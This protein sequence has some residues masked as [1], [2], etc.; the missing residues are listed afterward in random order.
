MQY[1][2]LPSVS[3]FA[4]PLTGRTVLLTGGNVGLG[5]EAAKHLA[6]LGPERL[7]ITSRNAARGAEAVKA[8]QA[9]GKGKVGSVECWEIDQ[10]QFGSVTA[11]ADRWAKE[12]GKLDLLV[13]NAG[14]AQLEY[15]QSQDGLELMLQVNHLAPALLTFRMLPFLSKASPDPPTPRIVIV[16]SGTHHWV[17]GV[18]EV[19]EAGDGWLK[20]LASKKYCQTEKGMM[21]RYPLTKLFNVMFAK[22]LSEHIPASNP[23]IANSVNPGFCRSSLGRNVRSWR[24]W[25]YTQL[26][27]RTTEVGS[28]TLVHAAVGKDLDDMYGEYV[29]SCFVSSP[30]ALVRSRRGKMIRDKLWAQTIE[31]LSEV[32]PEVPRIIKQYLE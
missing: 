6:S 28:R 29:E 20:L 7:I 18:Q 23:L 19:D 2:P 16:N 5:F 24:F 21:M 11:F 25:F 10:A 13:L 17:P 9:A 27:A 4:R 15:A 1:C 8:I 32:D 26:V 30:S 14:V 3:S 31:L 22:S 12:V